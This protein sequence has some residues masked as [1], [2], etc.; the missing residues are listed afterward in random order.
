[1]GSFDMGEMSFGE[2]MECPNGEEAPAPMPLN[3][4]QAKCVFESIRMDESHEC[5]NGKP[6]F[7]AVAGYFAQEAC[8][9]KQE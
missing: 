1:M 9:H 4:E 7:S 2:E 6:T 5:R 8:E 3:C